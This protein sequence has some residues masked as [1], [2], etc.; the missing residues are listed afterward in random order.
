MRKV[1]GPGLMESAYEERLCR[2]LAQA[3]I[4]GPQRAQ[5]FEIICSCIFF[6]CS[7]A[8]LRV[9]SLTGLCPASVVNVYRKLEDGAQDLSSG[10]PVGRCHIME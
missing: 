1:L 9:L 7:I 10:Q 5:R 6:V 4:T 2:A 8:S 3:F